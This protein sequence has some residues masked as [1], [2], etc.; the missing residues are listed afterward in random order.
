MVYTSDNES[1]AAF[2]KGRSDECFLLGFIDDA[3]VE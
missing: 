3:T 1:F 2:L